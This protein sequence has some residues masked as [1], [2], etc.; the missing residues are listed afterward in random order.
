MKKL[1]MVL[2]ALCLGLC[3]V[4]C[5]GKPSNMDQKTYDLGKEAVQIAEDYLNGR[6]SASDAYRKIDSVYNSLNS[7]VPTNSTPNLIVIGYVMRIRFE[8]IKPILLN[9]SIDKDEVKSALKELK[10]Y[11]NVR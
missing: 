6:T 2:L 4:S 5:G 8:F 3:A 9:D 10:E 11:I 7:Y 1:L